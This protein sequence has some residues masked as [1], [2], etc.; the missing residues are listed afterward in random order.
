MKQH[1]HLINKDLTNVSDT[2]GA[3]TKLAMRTGSA[4]KIFS[5]MNG[6]P[7]N[8]NMVDH[9]PVSPLQVPGDH[10]LGGQLLGGCCSCPLSNLLSP[11]SFARHSPGYGLSPEE[12]CH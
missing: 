8:Y 6:V 10:P 9:L 11:G 2:A 1:I 5:P 12:A 4:K 7:G 3:V